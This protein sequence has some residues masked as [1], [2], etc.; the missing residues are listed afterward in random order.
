MTETRKETNAEMETRIESRAERDGPTAEAPE[1]TRLTVLAAL[2]AAAAGGACMKDYDML[3]DDP[4]SPDPYREPADTSGGDGG[5][6]GGGG[7]H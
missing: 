4:L 2:S 1:R 3:E 6:G 5:G 7:S